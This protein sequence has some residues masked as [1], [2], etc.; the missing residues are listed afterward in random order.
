MILLAVC[1]CLQIA[2]AIKGSYNGS[3]KLVSIATT[4]NVERQVDLFSVSLMEIHPSIESQF[5]MLSY[6][7][8]KNN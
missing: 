7:I 8:H 2:A 6:N 4:A 3:G 5:I 1:F